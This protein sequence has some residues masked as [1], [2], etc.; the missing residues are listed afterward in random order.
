MILTIRMMN[1]VKP[2][3]RLVIVVASILV[4][5]FLYAGGFDAKLL[6]G[7]IIILCIPV[8]PTTY[9]FIEYYIVT[10]NQIVEIT[11]EAISVKNKNGTTMRYLNNDLK[12]IKLYK[13]AGMEK[14]SFPF[15][16]AEMF[17]H[18]KIIAKDGNTIIL[19]SFLGPKFDV[20]LDMLTDVPR[21]VTRTVYSTIYF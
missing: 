8:L 6:P 3:L 2:V 10:R 14:G 1:M 11:N 12:G 4:I 21:D 7:F 15:Q 13:S 9:L 5:G 20:A 19:T 16:T 17:Y 18:A